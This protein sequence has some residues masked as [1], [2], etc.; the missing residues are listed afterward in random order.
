MRVRDRLSVCLLSFAIFLPAGV[1]SAKDKPVQVYILAGQSNMDGYGGLE[2]LEYQAKHG[3]DDRQKVFG[4][5]LKEGE[6]VVRDDVWITFRDRKGPLTAGFGVNKNMMGVEWDF[7][8]VVGDHHD[9]K[10][11][12]IKTSWGGASIRRKFR[13]P[14]SGKPTKL[15]EEEYGK[16][17][18]QYEKQLEKAKD[19]K[20][21][22]AKPERADAENVFGTNY[23]KMLEVVHGTLADIKS[24]IPSYDGEGYEIA[25]FVWFQGFNDQFGGAHEE[26]ETHLANLIRD[27]RKEFKK[28]K[29]PVVVGQMGHGGTKAEREKR[30]LKP[31][32][33]PTRAIKAAQAA[34]CAMNEFEG[35]A[36]VV[37]TDVFWD[38]KAQAV[39]DKGW[40]KHLEEWKKIGAHFPFHYLGSPYFFLVTGNAFGEA[41]LELHEKQ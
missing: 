16:K 19:K 29:L 3:D 25:G 10:V 39:F 8:N 17:L 30:E 14:S 6:F 38:W 20:R 36:A 12:L 5:L 13:P 11:L 28:P 18:V 15:I 33:D 37:K 40:K 27:V 26:Y 2:A 41:M 4:H 9:A 24:V 1:L 34:V 22:P 21:K 31:I 35:S 32:G 23:R 7:G